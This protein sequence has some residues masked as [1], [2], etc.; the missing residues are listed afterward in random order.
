M[1]ISDV[2]TKIAEASI[3]GNLGLFIGAGFSKAV[4]ESEHS[5]KG[6]LFWIELLERVCKPLGV[7][8]DEVKKESKSCPEIASEICRIYSR[9]KKVRY[10]EATNAMKNEISKMTAWYPDD[11]QREE[12]SPLLQ[13]V[14]AKWIITTNYD[15]IIE[16]LLMDSGKSLGPN[17]SLVLSNMFVPIFHLH[18]IR[19]DPNSL[20]VTNED[21][22]ELFRP[23]EYRLQKLSLTLHEST[24]VM[25]GYG[26]GDPNVLTA[27][28]WSNNVYGTNKDRYPQG[29][30]QFVYQ[31][32]LPNDVEIVE[33]TDD[34]MIVVK[35]NSIKRALERIKNKV[36]D[37][38][39]EYERQKK[40][41]G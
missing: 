9:D 31:D 25:L 15:L 2:Y 18:G 8:W 34:K 28:D 7:D 5:D 21:Y 26:I 1:T 22:I 3:Y 23:N 37:V 35:T 39:E 38:R 40:S 12:F 19:T 10:E 6:P 4:F 16:S 30:I 32:G 36:A 41:C 17:D 20:I 24:T 13:G 14:N 27:L 29:V 11:E 33:I